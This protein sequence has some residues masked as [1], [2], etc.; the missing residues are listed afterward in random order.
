MANVKCGLI[1]MA[2]KGDGTVVSWGNSRTPPP[3]SNVVAIDAG[4]D[5]D[6]AL[7]GDGRAVSW[8]NSQY[9]AHIIP[10]ESYVAAGSISG[11][12]DVHTPGTSLKNR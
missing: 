6:F 5:H 8:G 3:L 2:L 9:G 7:L 1:Q 11:T 4:A 10:P 12:V